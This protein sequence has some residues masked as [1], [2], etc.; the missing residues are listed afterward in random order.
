M[1]RHFYNFLGL[2]FLGI[3]TLGIILPLLPTVIFYIIAAACFAK[4]NPRLEA[5]I[6]ERPHIGHYV[7]AWRNNRA[8]P[9][10]GKIAAIIGMSVGY[11][12][13]LLS[14]DSQLLV[15]VIVAL[16]FVAIGLYIISKPGY[17]PD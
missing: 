11:L 3:G 8:I 17:V 14:V 2:V 5:W 10:N 15:K 6:L 1:Q 7:I 4:S 12:F 9:R 16:T 13:F